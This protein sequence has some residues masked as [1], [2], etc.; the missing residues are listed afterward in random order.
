MKKAVALKYPKNATAPFIVAK[1][2]G[3]LAEKIIEIAK[4]NDVPL[5]ENDIASS[6]LTTQEI[7]SIVPE[8]LW[9]IVAK[10][11]AVVMKE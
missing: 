9:E 11:F 1:A 5:V 6:V 2:K 10:I 7:G 3:R 8:E 4:E